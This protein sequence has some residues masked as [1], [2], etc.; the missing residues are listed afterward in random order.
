[1]GLTFMDSFLRTTPNWL[2]KDLIFLFYEDMDYTLSV[3]E[4]IDT[5]FQQDE[6]HVD[7]TKL[8]T[9]KI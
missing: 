4:F 3:K 8:L 2:A 6:G 7:P 5:Y 9:N 1:M